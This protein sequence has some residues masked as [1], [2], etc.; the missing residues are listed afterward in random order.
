VRYF[1][2]LCDQMMQHSAENPATPINFDE[3]EQQ[4]PIAKVA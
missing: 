2:Q 1:E 3:M 4:S